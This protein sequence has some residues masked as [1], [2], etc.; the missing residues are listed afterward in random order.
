MTTF[1]LAKRG[2]ITKKKEWLIRAIAI[3][4][5]LILCAIITMIVTGINP[6]DFYAS[7]FQYGEKNMDYH[8]ESVR[9]VDY[10]PGAHS[11]I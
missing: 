1:H 2:E 7:I 10:L 6:I 5:A 4:A 9:S 8:S 3:L 11:C